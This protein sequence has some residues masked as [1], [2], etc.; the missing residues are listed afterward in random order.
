MSIFHIKGN[1]IFSITACR[2]RDSKLIIEHAISDVK[3]DENREPSGCI[4]KYPNFEGRGGPMNAKGHRS[5]VL[6][7]PSEEIARALYEDGW[8]VKKYGIDPRDGVRKTASFDT[9]LDQFEY[10]VNVEVNME[11]ETPPILYKK[12]DKHVMKLSAETAAQLD[13]AESDD[14]FL[15]INGYISTN[16]P[17]KDGLRSFY[18]N[19]IIMYV[20]NDV[21]TDIVTEMIGDLPIISE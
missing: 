16:K 10:R 13:V 12:T 8:R 1:E 6:V 17:P 4:V 9:D 11:G 21:A 15:E 19:Q 3:V 2:A 5:F 18:L 14:I 20:G 7:I